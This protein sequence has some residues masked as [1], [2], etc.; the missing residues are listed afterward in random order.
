VKGV[1]VWIVVFIAL[2]GFTFIVDLGGNFF[3]LPDSFVQVGFAAN[4]TLFLWLLARYVGRPMLAFL[5]T[6]REGIAEQLQQAERKLAEAEELRAEVSKRLDQVEQELAQLRDRAE[7]DARAEV[8]E[9]TE[10]TA[11]EEER[12]L[13]RVDDEITRRETEARQKLARETATLT[14]QLTR[15]L[16]QRELTEQDRQ[17]ILDSS[18]AAMRAAEKE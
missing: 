8:Q 6:R 15:E 11:L 13:K 7:N 4:L 5:D 14:A 12:F 3:G 1:G 16:L 17:R 2:L 10:Q 9:I 18:L